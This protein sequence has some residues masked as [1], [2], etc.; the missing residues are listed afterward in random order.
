M[1]QKLCKRDGLIWGRE[2]EPFGAVSNSGFGFGLLG[3]Q[4]L[5]PGSFFFLFHRLT[6][7][8]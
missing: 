3:S 6:G 8:K 5:L 1:V 4:Q 2:M 7:K